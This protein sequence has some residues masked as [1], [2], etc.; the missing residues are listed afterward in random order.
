M[1]KQCKS[2]RML[3]A[4]LT[5]SAAV[6]WVAAPIAVCAGEAKSV[7]VCSACDFQQADAGS[8]PKCNAALRKWNLTYEC[9]SCGMAQT[10]PGTCSMCG[11]ELKEK[12]SPA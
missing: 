4:L 11:T 6:A 1:L 2:L 9:V 3:C 12:K 7:F 5:G 8:C 10:H